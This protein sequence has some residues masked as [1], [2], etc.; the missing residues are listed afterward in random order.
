MRAILQGPISSKAALRARL[1]L[2]SSS[3]YF[4]A[5]AL[6]VTFLV[7][8]VGISATQR[9][10]FLGA[11]L[12]YALGCAA[13]IT[14]LANRLDA[15]IGDALDAGLPEPLTATA[16]RPVLLAVLG[17]PRRLMPL[18]FGAW[19]AA[20]IWVPACLQVRHPDTPWSVGATIALSCLFGGCLAALLGFFVTRRVLAPLRAR[21][22]IGAAV[23]GFESDVRP[24]PLA[25]KT[26]GAL[27]LATATTAIF[28]ILLCYHALSRTQESRDLERLRAT[29][30]PGAPTPPGVHVFELDLASD[31][32]APA[33][34]T[35]IETDWIRDHGGRAGDGA[36]LTSRHVFAWRPLASGSGRVLVATSGASPAAAAI[37]AERVPIALVTIFLMLTSVAI[38]ELLA[39]D[40]RRSFLSLRDQ[41]EHIA[42]GRLGIDPA[43]D[44]DE[45][46][47]AF[48]AFDRMRSSLDRIVTQVS[49]QTN[50]LSRAAT[51]L[52][53]ASQ[54]V[55]ATAKGQ[56]TSLE[57][58]ARFVSQIHDQIAALAA[59]SQEVAARIEG[60]A[61]VSGSVS[62]AGGRLGDHAEVL[63][64]HV[65]AAH[66]ATDRLS[67]QTSEVHDLSRQL[68]AAA[69]HTA[70]EA[71]HVASG[72]AATAGGT[73]SIRELSRG[74]VS[75]A[76]EGRARVDAASG[77]LDR[78]AGEMQGAVDFTASLAA[79]GNR[80]ESALHFID[81]VAD[82]THLLALNAAIIAARAGEEG[83]AFAV[84]ADQIRALARRVTEHT[85]AI[86][87]ATTS[88]RRQGDEATRIM[89]QTAER[90]VAGK[91][92]GAAAGAML[93]QIT[94]AARVTLGHVEE[95]SSVV[96]IHAE[97]TRTL[98][99]SMQEMRALGARMQTRNEEQQ[100]ACAVV[101]EANAVVDG[102]TRETLATTREQEG[103]IRGVHA[104]I[105]A[106][107]E[108]LSRVRSSLEVQ[109]TSC[110]E[111][112]TLLGDVFQRTRT[113]AATSETL[114]DQASEL[115]NRTELLRSVVRVFTRDA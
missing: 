87:T 24:I 114:R 26:R 65:D 17:L 91:A 90:T 41:A 66:A 9:H 1:Q 52:G 61:G 92:A 93:A 70:S 64:Q 108:E 46:G 19:V 58:A 63:A 113:A 5:M 86:E 60:V 102:L 30:V 97:A 28:A 112:A 79:Q 7:T 44:D 43:F 45:S 33:A 101:A 99:G 89:R 42:A 69:D 23:E 16:A 48:R 78:I 50:A 35:P 31:V 74:V 13:P 83:R 110:R 11:I 85:S 109:S 3:T 15:P 36:D 29:L 27:G 22:A 100:R 20:G 94:D 105:D 49:Q 107:R 115:T 14:L 40:L 82:E 56:E 54:D 111:A 25:M 51:S 77:E 62:E 18:H 67:S 71:E 2:A 59:A 37:E 76:E 96:G 104:S 73:D 88:L 4:A 98:A 47:A 53:G 34:L 103:A 10:T 32:A 75:L 106:A 95:I 8:V 84:I 6:F 21:L 12:L 55:A 72:L 80:I 57:R 68:A 81:E 39:A 38:G